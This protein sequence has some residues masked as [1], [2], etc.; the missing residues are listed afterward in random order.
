[1]IKK[2]ILAAFAVMVLAPAS[3]QSLRGPGYYGLGVEII[4]GDTLLTVYMAPVFRYKNGAVDRVRNYEKL[5]Y[6]LK[7][8][9]P[10]AKEA[11]RLLRETEKKML[12]I[13]SKSEQK[14]YIK[15]MED[16]LKKQYTPVLKSMTYSQG[17]LLIKLIDRETDHTSYELVKELRGSFSAFF[18]QSVARIFGANL[19]DAYDAEGD[20]KMVEQLII[21]IEAG[22]I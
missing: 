2:L 4:G 16:Q 12:A 18:W 7:K 20:D 11:N 15:Q 5:V 13:K 22:M 3:A 21:M 8:V 9:Y 14:A 19:K 1:M 17:K 6:N 10:I